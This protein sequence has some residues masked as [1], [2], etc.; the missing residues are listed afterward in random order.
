MKKTV[1][2]LTLLFTVVLPYN[3]SA[4][5]SGSSGYMHEDIANYLLDYPTVKPYIDE[6]VRYYGLSKSSM[7]STANSEPDPHRGWGFISSASS[8]HGMTLNNY[9]IGT[10]LHA[11]GDGSVAAQHDPAVFDSGT[12][13]DIWEATTELAG[14]SLPTLNYNVDVLMGSMTTKKETIYAEQIDLSQRYKTWYDAQ[15]LP[16]VI[17]TRAPHSMISEGL[18]NSLQMGEAMLKEYF[19]YKQILCP[20]YV[21]ADWR[22]EEGTGQYAYSSKGSIT[23]DLQLGSSTDADGSDPDWTSV[24]FN[25]TKGIRFFKYSDKGASTYARSTGKWTY[26]E[27]N[28]VAPAGSYSIEVIFRPASWPTASSPSNESEMCL[29]KCSD[30]ASGGTP[31]Y[32][33]DLINNSL[34]HKC[35]RFEARHNDGTSTELV[36]DVPAEMGFDI[37]MAKWYYVCVAFDGS[38]LSMMFRDM[39]TGVRK[40]ISTPCTA[41]SSWTANPNPVF[42]I[43]SKYL[44]SGGNCFDGKI[45]R[46]RISNTRLSYARRLYLYPNVADWKFDENTGQTVANSASNGSSTLQLQFGSSTSA[47]ASD[48][49]WTAG[50]SNYAMLGRKYSAGNVSVYSMNSGWTLKDAESMS[51]GNSYSIEMF[52][53][54]TTLPTAGSYS[55]DN[56][57]GLIKYIDSAANKTLY[58]MNLLI[59][60]SGRQ[61]LRFYANHDDNTSTTYV[62]DIQAAG[63][64]MTTGKWYYVGAIYTDYPVNA[65]TLE[66][67]VRDMS[68]GYTVSGTTTSK[69]LM[70]LSDNPSPLLTVGSE[71]TT[72]SGRC[73]NGAIDRVRVSNMSIADGS[74]LYG[75]MKVGDWGFFNADLNVDG[76]VNG[77]DLRMLMNNW[78]FSNENIIANG[79]AENT[80]DWAYW[81]RGGT[82]SINR[83]DSASAGTSCF[84]MDNTSSPSSTADF[85]CNTIPVTPGETM[86]LK[87]KY[88]TA[89]GFNLANIAGLMVQARFHSDSG[90]A[91]CLGTCDYYLT[92]TDG[93]WVSKEYA[94]NVGSNSS[95]AYLDVRA[96]LNLF[97][98]AAGQARLDDFELNSDENAIDFQDFADFALEWMKCSDP[99]NSACMHV[100]Y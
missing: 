43:G 60:N 42:L 95:I 57:M 35:V 69:H 63:L 96:S 7:V 23:A 64:T 73:F 30:T 72:S 87:F 90:A 93:Q 8:L 26:F 51:P 28:A 56:P 41:L 13:H 98:T 31:K 59:N 21:V 11:A 84:E 81:H 88:K 5:W 71:Y 37:E 46:V 9:T 19:D 82:L 99:A 10:I 20:S 61:A 76:Y 49:T 62:F 4:Y 86:R 25:R 45:D 50:Y 39:Q 100:I 68:T 18:D 67:I 53:N 22:F 33:L 97:G 58:F 70:P 66:L 36:F 27:A 29:V 65:G 52:I 32:V 89:A 83:T 40:D 77:V 34:N 16:N 24:G 94:F 1:C 55:V 12:A 47:D 74:R 75:G 17:T 15:T 85:R 6:L 14:I 54:P 48:P 91:N 80:S 2:I 92:P 3:A 38:T 78:L 79:D 44:T